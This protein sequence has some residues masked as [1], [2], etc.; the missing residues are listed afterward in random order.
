VQYVPRVARLELT[1]SPDDRRLYTLPG[2]GELRTRRW[3][4]RQ[5]E[6]TTSDG[7]SYVFTTRR[8]TA[9]DAFGGEVA[10]QHGSRGFLW[11]SVQW[12]LRPTGDVSGAYALVRPG[13]EDEL[14]IAMPVGWGRRPVPLVVDETARLDPGL[15]LYLLFAMR[16]KGEAISSSAA[17]S[18]GASAG[19]N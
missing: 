3:P 7:R 14:A 8:W 4:S 12:E 6:A 2:I 19:G 18:S 9:V 5:V 16:A 17:R 13:E 15:V 11:R 10:R 1:R